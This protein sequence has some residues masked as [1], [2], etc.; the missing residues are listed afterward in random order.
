MY[1][2]LILCFTYSPKHNT[3]V[4]GKISL[5]M[6]CAEHE[7]LSRKDFLSDV[8]LSGAGNEVEVDLITGRSTVPS[9]PVLSGPRNNVEGL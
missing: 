4:D 3:G 2:I 7:L 8:Q 6:E 5:I 1:H 9:T